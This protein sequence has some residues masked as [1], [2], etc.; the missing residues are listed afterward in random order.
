M[1]A[2]FYFG[3]TPDKRGFIME[4]QIDKP[5]MPGERVAVGHIVHTAAELSELVALLANAREQMDPPIPEE[6]D[7]NPRVTG[8]P[9]TAFEL[10]TAKSGQGKV[11]ILRHPGHG[12]IGYALTEDQCQLLGTGLLHGG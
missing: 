4:L 6:L 3:M 8:T 10:R 1:G 11:L 7:P 9:E 12:W 5:D 2:G